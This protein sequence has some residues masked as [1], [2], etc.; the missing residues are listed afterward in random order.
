MIKRLAI[1]T[2]GGDSPGMNPVIRSV[3]RTGLNNGM[4]VVGIEN[5]YQGIFDHE[6]VPLGVLEVSGK[7]RD[8]GTFLATS[9]CQRMMEHNGPQE[10][11][12][13]LR[14]NK[15]DGLIVCGG[16][17]SLSGAHIIHKLGY[18]VL[19][20]PGTIDNDLHG[21][22]ISLGVDTALNTIITMIDMIKATAASHRR[23]FIIEVMGRGSGYL[24]LMSTI[25]TGSQVAIIPEYRYNM[26]SVV[27]ALTRR[28]ERR[29]NNSTIVVAEGACSGQELLN[30]LKTEGEKK[31]NQEI[32]LTVLGHVQRGGAPT[33]FDRLLGTRMGEF[34]V[35]A[36]MHGETGS[37]VS[38]VNG[39]MNLRDFDEILGRK[40]NLPADA[41]R[42]AKNLGIELGDV[43]ET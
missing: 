10:A 27:E 39:K 36:L 14:E 24:A 19:G 41:M 23:C 4:E 40:K 16:D 37:M 38:L 17:G 15:I 29:H 43:M 42:L 2:S 22:D 12:Q 30:K 35:L 18:P 8:A 21:T 7:I 28:R 31:L 32:R 33:H 13:I 9:R 34:G 3:T 25:S 1:L 20:I 26:N 11:I 5:G 6:F